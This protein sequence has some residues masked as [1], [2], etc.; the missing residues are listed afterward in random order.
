MKKGRGSYVLEG[1]GAFSAPMHI[2]RLD[3]EVSNLHGWQ[4]RPPKAESQFFADGNPRN[5]EAAL[6]RAREY[7]ISRG[8]QPRTR[9]PLPRSERDY[10]QNNTGVVGVY[11]QR[12]QR[13]RKGRETVSYSFLVPRPDKSGPCRTLYIGSESTWQ[14]NYEY[15]LS[16]AREIRRDFEEQFERSATAA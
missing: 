16:L 12:R 14:L 6:E 1:F 2:V 13:V 8:L 7:L 5:P 3:S 10:K 15:K 4:V 11:L 9:R